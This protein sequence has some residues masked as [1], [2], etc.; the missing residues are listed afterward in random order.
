M[1]NQNAHKFDTIIAKYKSLMQAAPDQ[2]GTIALQ[3]FKEDTFTAQGQIMGASSVK[4]W[5]VRGNGPKNRVGAALLIKSGKLRRD[6]NY[7]KA[8]K[9]VIV[10]SELPYSKLQND[11]GVIPVTSK[12]RKFFWAMFKQSGDT[13]WRGMALT[14]K[15]HFNIKPRPFLYDTP[16]LP[17]RLDN[18]FKPL[19]KSIIQT[20]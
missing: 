3:L 12:M 9:K 18:Y 8:G 10:K 7:R 19:I 15:P 20:S 13:F 14:K 16:E 11:G 4:K 6:L 2:V 1:E 17:R 5:P